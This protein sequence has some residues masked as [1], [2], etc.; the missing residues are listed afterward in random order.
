MRWCCAGI[1]PVAGASR[2]ASLPPAG[3]ALA[4]CLTSLFHLPDACWVTLFACDHRNL[5]VFLSVM[6]KAE[7]K[8][9]LWH[10]HVTALTI[11]PEYRRLGMAQKTMKL[12]E[13]ISDKR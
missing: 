5:T 2:Y 9:K 7:G 11:G 8:G 12:L 10:G 3:L 1:R 6:G 13:T 4:Q